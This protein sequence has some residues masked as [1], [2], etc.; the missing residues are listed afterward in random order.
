MVYTP[1]STYNGL[2]LSHEK[3][4]NVAI[5]NNTDKP[6]DT[7]LGDISQRETNLYIFIYMWNLKNKWA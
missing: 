2:L 5:C 1:Y 7:V 6:W 4:W 3:E